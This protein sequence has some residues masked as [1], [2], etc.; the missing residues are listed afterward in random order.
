M[1]RKLNLANVLISTLVGLML[2]LFTAQ[3]VSV[4]ASLLTV[5]DPSLDRF[6]AP[7]GADDSDCTNS[8]DPCRSVRFAVDQAMDGETIGLAEGTYEVAVL[9]AIEV[10]R[11]LNLRG[12]WDASFIN[13]TGTSTIQNTIWIYPHAIAQVERLDINTPETNTYGIYVTYGNLIIRD[14]AVRDNRTGIW[15]E[16]GTAK[17]INTTVSG[18]GFVPGGNGGIVSWY[19]NGRNSVTVINSTITNNQGNGVGGLH[20]VSGAGSFTIINSIVIGNIN[21]YGYEPDCKGDFISGGYNIIGN[22]YSSVCEGNWLGTDIIGTFKKPIPVERVLNQVLTQDPVNGQ[23]YHP[24]VPGP[25]VDAGNPAIPGSSGNACP[26]TDQ[27]GIT[28]PRGKYCDIG[29]VESEYR[30]SSLKV[31]SNGSRDGWTLE[32]TETS[33]H[34][35]TRN[36]TGLLNIGD[37]AI[38][39][40]YRTILFFNTAPLPDNAVI[41]KVILKIK[42]QGVQGSNPFTTLGNLIADIQKGYFGNSALE[43]GDFQATAS[44]RKIGKFTTTNAAPG[45]YSL[46]LR[47]GDYIYFSSINPVSVTQFRLYFSKDDNDNRVEDYIKFYSGDTSVATANRPILIINYVLP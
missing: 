22:T 21:I 44:R 11:D 28:R 39:K 19:A 30:V 23:W 1:N 24:L 6:V 26:A 42:K 32:S 27:L 7:T 33:N 43:V 5:P 13:Q 16:G 18:N 10:M 40:Q 25:A 9:P 14:S 8:E 34:G 12:G 35:G 41:T 47:G 3:P 17:I 2:L 4:N 38:D 29:A 45:W 15:V 46:L 37:G 36:A 20:N 31:Q